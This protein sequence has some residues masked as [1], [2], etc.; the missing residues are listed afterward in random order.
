MKEV[1]IEL[2]RR[3]SWTAIYRQQSPQLWGVQS[4]S[5]LS[6][7]ETKGP[8]HFTSRWLVIGHV[9]PSEKDVSLARDFG[10]VPKN[11]P[12]APPLWAQPGNNASVLK[13]ESGQDT[14]ASTTQSK[15]ESNLRIFKLLSHTHREQNWQ[16]QQ[17]KPERQLALW[18]FLSLLFMFI[19]HFWKRKIK[20]MIAALV[21]I[22]LAQWTE[23]P[24][25]EFLE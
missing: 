1:S 13:G 12:P 24:K 21:W 18:E 20:V 16:W 22:D 23:F 15:I 2:G 3:R 5:E 11:Q 6:A 7:F 10:P 19:S 17:T 9:P 14:I 4:P 25:W 8:H